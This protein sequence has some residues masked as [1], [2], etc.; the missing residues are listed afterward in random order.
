MPRTLQFKRY[1]SATLANTTGA[2][3][4]LI[5]NSTNK[6]LTVH[7]GV[8]PGGFALLNTTTDSNIDQYVRNTANIATSN[9]TILQGVNA[10]QNTNITNAFNLAQAA[11]NAAN[12]GGGGAIQPYL[13]LTDSSFI[14][15]PVVL[16]APV[17]ITVP[18]KGINALID[19][20]ILRGEGPYIDVIS[21]NADNRGT[22]YV[23][24][25]NYRIPYY[26]IG[27]S[28]DA[29]SIDFTV[30]TV[31]V[32]GTLLTIT[33]AG[34]VGAANNAEGEYGLVGSEAKAWVFDDISDGVILARD[35]NQGIYNT[36]YE[37][38]YDNQNY[39]SPAGT[40]WNSDGWGTLSG[41]ETRKYTTW[42]EALDG[43]VGN[44]IVASELVMHDIRDD[45]FYKF[46]FTAW[47]GSNGG[48]SYTRREITD[49]NYFRKLPYENGSS[50]IDTIIPGVLAI[51]RDNNGGIYNN[52]TEEGWNEDVSPE[53]TL[54]NIDG[55]NDLTDLTDRTYDNLYAA[56]GNGGLGN[57]IVGTECVMFVPSQNK[58]YAIKFLSWTQNNQGGGFSYNRYEIDQTKLNEG[59]KF[60]DG[61]VQKTAYIPTTVK[62]TAPRDRRIEEVFGYKEVF[63]TSGEPNSV[64]WWD[65]ADLPNGG[66]NFRGAV[67]DYHAYTGDSTI[68]GTIHIVDDDGEENIT[69]TEVSS[70]ST[71][72][73]ND[74]LWLVTNEGQIRYRRLDNEAS[75]LK[76]HWTAKV[77]YGS[78][79]YD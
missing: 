14:V 25:Q 49:T 5:I 78:E 51:R 45:K 11:Y 12:T 61:T 67:I 75:I 21:V 2:N 7:D 55:W 41:V 27:G 28:T 68:I 64:V 40:E 50:G 42:R 33:D 30:A 31:G 56:F 43:N 16:G 22:G 44:N 15:E 53:G 1:G 34:F 26:S 46:D 6:T 74:D 35:G 48:Y 62:S 38:E 10:T 57:K 59:V 17:T 36:E 20:V 77:F 24:G 13:E 19:V 4:E 63:V 79:L 58:Y 3:G 54:W 73:M 60:A 8:T 47:N 76:I 18:N 72:G 29:S 70:G 66:G 71:D 39:T 65:S 32:G 23:V 9:I 37:P 52:V 69:H